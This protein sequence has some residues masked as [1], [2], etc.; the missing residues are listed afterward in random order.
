M[1]FG[2]SRVLCQLDCS[3]GVRAASDIPRD[4]AFEWASEKRCRPLVVTALQNGTKS[5]SDYGLTCTVGMPLRIHYELLSKRSH[6]F[7]MTPQGVLAIIIHGEALPVLYG[8]L[9]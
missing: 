7:V 9:H 8:L 3:F 1:Q 2:M 5:Q 4:A 6:G